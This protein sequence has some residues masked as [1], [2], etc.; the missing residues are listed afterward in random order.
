MATVWPRINFEREGELERLSK[1]LGVRPDVLQEASDRL[2]A[3]KRG[4]GLPTRKG[5]KNREKGFPQLEL[6]FP[7]KIYDDWLTWCELRNGKSQALIRGLIHDYLLD[8]WEPEVLSSSWIYKNKV[9]VL[10]IR[11]WEEKHHAAWPYRERIFVTVGAK[12]ALHFRATRQNISSRALLRGL[13]LEA[14]EG[15]TANIRPVDARSMYDD[16]L[17]YSK[18]M[19]G[20]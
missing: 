3:E 13:I 17:R 8:T 18:H 14:L 11:L 20:T 1:A 16:P 10:G 2:D 4:R 15:R 9:H 19:E 7:E 5:M 12:Q 6:D